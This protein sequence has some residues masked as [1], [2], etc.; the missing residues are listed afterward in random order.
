MVNRVKWASGVCLDCRRQVA[1]SSLRRN[2]WSIRSLS[3]V[4]NIL[5]PSQPP[6]PPPPDRLD[7][8]TVTRPRE[9]RKLLRSRVFPI[10][11]RRRRAALKSSQNIPFEQLPYQCFQEARKILQ[12]D[13]QEKLKLIELERGRIQRLL[14]QPTND[15]TSA[16]RK[17]IRLSSMRRH[18]E[19]LKIQ[20]DINDPLVKKKFEDG[21]GEFFHRGFVYIC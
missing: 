15:A 10:G 5:P 18:L 1:G 3:T 21:Q 13:R 7:P 8:R 17:E 16:S 4:Q 2:G 19:W 12:D 9:E 11:S 14:E 20:A 6:P